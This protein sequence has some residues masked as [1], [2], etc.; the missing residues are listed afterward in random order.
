MQL[1]RY[2]KEDYIRLHLDEDLVLEG[3]D[4]APLSRRQREELKL[5]VLRRLVERL[6]RSGKV[7]NPNKLLNDLFHREKR[8]HMYLGQGVALPHVRT[9]QARGLAM[10][11]GVAD[12]PIPWGDEPGQEADLFL[13]IVA[14]PYEDKTYLQV[15]KRIGELFARH[16]AAA[17]LRRA[18][19]P[20]EII[21]Y[22]NA[23][24]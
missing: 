7:N 18:R 23:V 21:R 1:T 20:G 24:T 4:G 9:M 12:R 16:D 10:A 8:H 6:D 15:Y 14:P 2:L 22:L 17:E 19:S 3:E 11:I 5:E 13:A